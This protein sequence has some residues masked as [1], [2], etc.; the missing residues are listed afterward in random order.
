MAENTLHNTTGT[1]TAQPKK[2]F[3][4]VLKDIVLF[5]F[6]LAWKLF[7]FALLVLLAVVLT[8]TVYCANQA[9]KP[10]TLPEAPKGM[11]Y[12]QFLGERLTAM[13]TYDEAYAKRWN[14]TDWLSKHATSIA[15]FGGFGMYTLANVPESVFAVLYPGSKVDKWLKA[16]DS[17]YSFQLPKG[18]A[19]WSNFF[20]LFW[21]AVQRSTWDWMVF[22]ENKLPLPTLPCG[23]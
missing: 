16:G 3:R 18:E 1:L 15:R 6:R 2:T 17:Q 4:S 5:P 19:K 8:L 12:Y 7:K 11:T 14:K 9:F 13:N 20:P 22:R 21:E 10:M 23:R